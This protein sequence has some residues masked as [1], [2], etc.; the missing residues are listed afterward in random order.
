MVDG[1]GGEYMEVITNGKTSKVA[2]CN[3]CNCTFRYSKVDISNYS[4]QKEVR[5]PECGH[6]I[7][8]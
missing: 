6:S 2:L 7:K 4:G 8:I 1:I 5:C 3:E